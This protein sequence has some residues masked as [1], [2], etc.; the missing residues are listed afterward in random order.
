MQPT[1]NK[2]DYEKSFSNELNKLLEKMRST[3]LDEVPVKEITTEYFIVFALDQQ[4]SMLYKATNGFLSSIAIEQLHDELYERIQPTTFSAIRPN[5]KVE[6]SKEFKHIMSKSDEEKASMG[7]KYITSD[8]ILLS[9]LNENSKSHIKDIFA[10]K[11]LTY[12]I[13][14]DES[15]KLHNLT[16][17][18]VEKPLINEMPQTITVIADGN[19]PLDF[20]QITNI[21]GMQI[22][23]NRSRK[24]KKNGIQFC[25]NLNGLASIG[26]IDPVIGRIDVIQ[27]IEKVFARRKCNNVILVG[28]SGS[29]KTAIV[30]GLAR[31][32]HDKKAPMSLLNKTIYSMKINDVL[33]GTNLRGMF[34]E[35]VAKIFT[36]LKEQKNCVLFIDDVQAIV[37]S[38]KR[39]DFDLITAMGEYINDSDI[40]IILATT[41]SGYK[42]VM[43]ANGDM[44]RRFHRINVEPLNVNDTINV[45]KQIKPIYEKFHNVIY[46]DDIIEAC[47]KLSDRYVTDVP[48][49]TS[50]INIMDEAG[51]LKKLSITQPNELKE[52]VNK[53]NYL[54]DMKDSF[55]R[56]DEVEKGEALTKDIDELKAEI[57]EIATKTE[58][59]DKEKTITIDDLNK[60]VSQHTDIP[61]S[62]ITVSER[63]TLARIKDVLKETVIG[64]DEALETIA[65]A[66]KRNKIGLYKK[67]KPILSAFMCGSSGVGK[68]LTAKTLAKE[69]FGD[70]KYLIRFDMS[71]YADKTSVNK[72]IGAGAGY[73][74]YDNGGLLTEAIKNKKH[75]VLLFDEIE[76]ADDEVYNLL[77]QV[78]DE[79]ML[80]DNMGNKVD[81]KNTIIIFTSNVGAKKAAES[82]QIGF[83]T[84]NSTNR[85]DIIEK[86][87]KKTFPP[88]F[89]NRLDDVVYYNDLSD[90]DM[91]RII[92]L[93]L[94]KLSKRIE[95]IGYSMEYD[96]NA[97][98]FIFNG[99]IE[100]RGYGARPVIRL[101][102]KHIEN[103]ITDMIIDNDYESHHFVVSADQNEIL[104]DE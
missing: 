100:E 11:G 79:A 87:L 82:H 65:N 47:V 32:I 45:L 64:Q 33:S 20:S 81:F 17:E 53:F 21:V 54:M 30:E 59:N 80:T 78:L 1:G 44:K 26:K 16:T 10:N 71:E 70:E 48:L 7:A 8:H 29:G 52:K 61:V 66:I 51:A 12:S 27:K 76:K 3:M 68:T 89:I 69:I 55:I 23:G 103:K 99:T 102:E 101:I 58:F 38:S 49:P 4:D 62:K 6:Y 25:R 13:L 86:E 50:A 74:G 96:K 28:K 92:K 57:T 31:M 63:K 9:I 104:I 41:Q 22:G 56:N 19:M 14:Y 5:K 83:I 97:V 60:A 67:Q 24:E 88:E 18:L 85:K 36:S 95:G 2:I 15:V 34:E 93:E 72:L 90:D 84:N 77:L 94:D 91:D 43:N 46:T 98:D 39:D 37:N 73:I 42:T 35:R 40:Q 75:A